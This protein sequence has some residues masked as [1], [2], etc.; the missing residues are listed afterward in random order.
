VLRGS[1]TGP[2]AMG[3]RMI[4]RAFLF[5]ARPVAEPSALECIA[6]AVV[7]VILARTIGVESL[8]GSIG[9]AFGVVYVLGLLR[10]A[11]DAAA[12]GRGA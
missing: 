6:F 4:K 3:V 10:L 9:V 7:G 5:L 1:S 11:M 2:L 8:L 12:G